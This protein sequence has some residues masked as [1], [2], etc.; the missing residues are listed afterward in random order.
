[1]GN[2]VG[3]PQNSILGPILFNLYMLPLGDVIR[4]HGIS[5]HSYA[6]HSQLFTAVSPDD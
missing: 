5:F 3:V 2:P 1:M 6:D 4:G